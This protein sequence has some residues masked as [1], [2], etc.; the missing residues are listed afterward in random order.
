[1]RQATTE[2]KNFVF[3]MTISFSVEIAA[4]RENIPAAD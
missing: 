1:M 2:H 4:R 3:D